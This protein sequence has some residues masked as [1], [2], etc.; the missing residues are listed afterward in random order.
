ML[1]TPITPSW[2][3]GWSLLPWSLSQRTWQ[4]RNDACCGMTSL[5]IAWSFFAVNTLQ[6]IVNG[7]KNP[8]IAPCP[9]DFVTMPE[10]DGATAIYNMQKIGKDCVCG[11]RE[12]LV[13]RETHRQTDAL[14][15]IHH[16][17]SGINF[18]ILSVNL[19]PVPLSLTSLLMLLPHLLTLSTYHS[20]HS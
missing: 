11:S 6:C 18:L 15:T 9:C 20:H 8:K 12:I 17:V 13:D 16:H 14:I 10:E 2:P 7:E 1:C 19:I 4:R 5:A 3:I